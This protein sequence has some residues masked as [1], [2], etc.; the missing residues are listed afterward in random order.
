MF[1]VTLGN[2]L[3]FVVS[4]QK[5]SVW[6]PKKVAREKYIRANVFAAS[7][8]V[9]IHVEDINDHPPRFT[10]KVYHTT[11]SE[12]YPV[13]ASITS[14]SASDP[15][16]GANA[17]MTYTLKEQDREYFYMSSV[18]A[19]NTGVLKIFKVSFVQETVLCSFL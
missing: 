10:Q 13:G 12:N 8:T 11:M 17:K 5:Y 18:E 2:L 4:L 14:V 9:T 15:D 6:T 3:V 19:T 16:V 7:A 1:T